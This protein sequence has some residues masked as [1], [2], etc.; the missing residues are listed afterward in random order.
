MQF[1]QVRRSGRGAAY[2][3]QVADAQGLAIA[4]QPT[5]LLAAHGASRAE[6]QRRIHPAR[7]G[8]IA[9]GADGWGGKHQLLPGSYGKALPVGQRLA[10]QRGL[11]VRSGDGQGA[12]LLAQQ[13]D[14]AEGYFQHRAIGGITEQPV[15]PGGGNPVQRAALG[16]TDMPCAKAPAVLQLGQPQGA[17]Y[18]Q[19]AHASGSSG[20]SSPPW[21][22]N[23]LRSMATKRTESPGLSRL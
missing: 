20:V 21:R 23:S 11:Q 18:P 15:G 13:S 14:S 12:A 19:A 6:Q 16:H 3:Q 10:I 9:A 8:Q 7:G 4:V 22:R 5:Q 17:F 2:C 1:G